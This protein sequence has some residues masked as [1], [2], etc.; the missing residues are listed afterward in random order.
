MSE[1]SGP[2][3][4]ARFPTSAFLG[5]L[6]Q[7]FRDRA[8]A[9]I[10]A[11]RAAGATVTISATYRPAERAYLMH[12][13]CMIAES[14]QDPAHVPSF[15]GVGIDWSHGGDVLAARSAARAMMAAYGIAFPAA[16]VS[17]HTQKRAVDMTVHFQ[18]SIKVRGPDGVDH[19]AA[20]QGD[21]VPVGRAFQVFKLLSDPPH[22]SDDGH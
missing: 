10:G 19:Q 14:G 5:D 2:A 15:P 12:W 21:L 8:T 1:P 22:W 6:V 3:W 13:C 17:R 16:L 20:S 9:F 7:P 11:L 18:G 4:C